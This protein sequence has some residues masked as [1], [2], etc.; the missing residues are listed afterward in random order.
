MCFLLR[1]RFRRHRSRVW[2]G[3]WNFLS[4]PRAA[5]GCRSAAPRSVSPEAPASS[6]GAPRRPSPRAKSPAPQRGAAASPRGARGR[7]NRFPH[8][9][10]LRGN[11]EAPRR[12]AYRP[13]RPPALPGAP[14][15]PSLRAKLFSSPRSA[16]GRVNLSD[17]CVGFLFYPPLVAA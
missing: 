12:G 16:W 8:S 11:A 13:G 1:R 2:R 3:V 10:A 14:Q 17:K 9:H 15:R 5:W 6:P 7:E 4:F